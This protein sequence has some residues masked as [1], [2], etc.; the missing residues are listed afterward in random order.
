MSFTSFIWN[1]TEYLAYLCIIIQTGLAI[2]GPAVILPANGGNHQDNS[3]KNMISTITDVA[4]KFVES[5]NIPASNQKLDWLGLRPR[6]RFAPCA[7]ASD[8]G[9]LGRKRPRDL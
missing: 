7:T 6:D 1:V 9:F 3:L 5:S 4:N 8:R 2:L